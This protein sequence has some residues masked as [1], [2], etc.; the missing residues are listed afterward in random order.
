M[1]GFA[2]EGLR[3]RSALGV[4]GRFDLAH[5]RLT[6]RTCGGSKPNGGFLGVDAAR[7][8]IEPTYLVR[9]TRSPG[10][11]A[12]TVLDHAHEESNASRSVRRSTCGGKRRSPVESEEEDE[13]SDKPLGVDGDRCAC[14]AAR[15]RLRQIVAGS[16]DLIFLAWSSRN[17]RGA[18]PTVGREHAKR[19]RP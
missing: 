17:V 3:W 11:R 15:R 2:G 6:Q 5:V 12:S 1:T 16:V 8:W 4:V 13:F 18:S 7:P 19:S 10:N 9:R 14:V